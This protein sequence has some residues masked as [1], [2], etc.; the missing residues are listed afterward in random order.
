MSLAAGGWRIGRSGMPIF[1]SDAAVTTT[2]YFGTLI[3]DGDDSTLLT[4]RGAYKPTDTIRGNP[5]S[6]DLHKRRLRNIEH[7]SAPEIAKY[8]I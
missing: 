3:V 2:V 4:E 8:L 5:L 1:Y 7:V 6:D